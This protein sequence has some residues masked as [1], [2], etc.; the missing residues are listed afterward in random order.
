MDIPT[1]AVATILSALSVALMFFILSIFRKEKSILI[2][3]LAFLSICIG[4]V[5]TLQFRGQDSLVA[6][7]IQPGDGQN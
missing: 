2:F 1:L 3:A 7:F 5:L 4:L 6:I